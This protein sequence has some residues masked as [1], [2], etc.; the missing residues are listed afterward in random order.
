M[1]SKS[2][3]MF[4]LLVLLP[5]FSCAK[6]HINPPVANNTVQ[7]NTGVVKIDNAFTY[8]GRFQY[9][10]ASGYR[11]NYVKQDSL[12]N[13]IWSF[14]IFADVHKSTPDRFVVIRKF[15]LSGYGE[16][17][18]VS[19]PISDYAYNFKI[20]GQL[21]DVTKRISAF[22]RENGYTMNGLYNAICFG[23]TVTSQCVYMVLY[24][25]KSDMAIE[26]NQNK[27]DLMDRG[28]ISCKFY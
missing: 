6:S 5:L 9:A 19:T 3:I 1:I 13:Q 14:D 12:P 21:N 27:T 24:I 26:F 2:R 23:G 7:Y 10:L 18:D 15:F 8:V 28:R 17:F 11:T 25:E 20:E 16:T 4:A 22:L